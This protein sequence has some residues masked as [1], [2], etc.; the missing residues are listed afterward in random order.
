[1]HLYTKTFPNLEMWE[2]HAQEKNFQ[3]KMFHKDTF[4]IPICIFVDSLW[5]F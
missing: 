2:K 5:G 4:P 1:M 3:Q